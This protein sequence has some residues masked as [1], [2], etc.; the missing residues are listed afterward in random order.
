MIERVSFDEQGG[1]DLDERRSSA[2]TSA[3]DMLAADMFW[4]TSTNSRAPA[5][6]TAIRSSV[7]YAIPRSF[8]S[9]TQPRLATSGSHS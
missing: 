7:R 9:T 1:V 8:V 5:R 6:A 2:A 4:F 3:A